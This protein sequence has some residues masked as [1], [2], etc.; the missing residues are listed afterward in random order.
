MGGRRGVVR[1]V[2]EGVLVNGGL[3]RKAPAA[4]DAHRDAHLEQRALR[5]GS[6]LDAGNRKCML[7]IG[8]RRWK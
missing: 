8:S 6:G 1:G 2:S 4:H 5:G 7:E 3:D